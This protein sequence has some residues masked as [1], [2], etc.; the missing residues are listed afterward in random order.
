[1]NQKHDNTKDI[2]IP[3]LV[4]VL[5]GTGIFI[6]LPYIKKL[7]KVP[8]KP[9]ATQPTTKPTTQPALNIPFLPPD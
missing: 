7:K 8:E 4:G 9:P 3:L 6:S 1:M 5:M 2:A